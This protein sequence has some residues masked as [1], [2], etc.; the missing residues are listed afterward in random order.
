MKT[1]ADHCSTGT[2]T[3]YC[4]MCYGLVGVVLWPSGADPGHQTEDDGGSEGENSASSR[5]QDRL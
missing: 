2:C 4:A 5:R 1:L 3:L